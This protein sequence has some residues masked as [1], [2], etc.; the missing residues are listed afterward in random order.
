MNRFAI[1]VIFTW[2]A[3]GLTSGGAEEPSPL[4]RTRT[5]LEEWVE[6]RQLISRTRSDWQTDKEMLEQTVL[7][8][9]RELKSIEEQMSKVSTNS[10]QV[11]K[12]LA[13]AEASLKSSSAGLDRSKQFAA[14]FETRIAKV[15]PQLPAPLQDI[16]KPLL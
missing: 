6:T 2:F 1:T 3:L 16:L 5:T 11:D 15:V 4:T 7:L 10:T 14:E 9:E 12:E 8:H 13:Q